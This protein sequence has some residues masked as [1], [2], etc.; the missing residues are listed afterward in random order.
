VA[1]SPDGKLVGSADWGGV[2]HLWDVITGKSCR[3]FEGGLGTVVSIAF[4]PD[5]A[6]LA[7]AAG[8]EHIHF[9]DV[10]SGREIRKAKGHPESVSMI[11]F[12]PDGQTV[13]VASE[14]G[15]EKS[16]LHLLWVSTGDLR[17]PFEGPRTRANCIAFSPDGKMLASAAP[18]DGIRVWEVASGR[19][20]QY[21]AGFQGTIRSVA[22]SPDGGRLVSGSTDTTALVWDLLDCRQVCEP[23]L[24]SSSELEAH[25]RALAGADI[26]SAFRAI[27]RFIGSPEQSVAFLSER[28][29]PIPPVEDRRVTELLTGLDSDD[30]ATRDQATFELRKYQDAIERRLRERL[31]NSGSPEV[32]RRAEQL[33]QQFRMPLREGESLRM[34][35]VLEVLEHIGTPKARQIIKGLAQGAPEAYLTREAKAALARSARRIPSRP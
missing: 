16:P 31:A 23:K 21:L 29:L 15:T 22:F 4:S 9:W 11:A 25:W 3:R 19:Q 32:R 6:T 27:R 24:E 2:L 7:A 1:Y 12:S 14:Y 33:L 10:A 13:A 34:L 8:D 30:F 18:G 20:R 17:Y 26:E 35:R 28:A 5:G